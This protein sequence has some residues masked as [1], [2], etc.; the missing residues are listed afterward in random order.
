MKT[1]LLLL[2]L[3]AN[4]SIYSQ[5][6]LVPNGDFED[7]SSSSQPD[8]GFVF[9]VVLFLKVQQLKMDPQVLK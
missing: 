5:T 4:F 8:T 3:L 7:W 1:K 6:N 2:L 9:L